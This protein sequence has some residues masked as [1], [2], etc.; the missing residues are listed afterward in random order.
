MV[1]GKQAVAKQIGNAVPA[2]LEQAVG[3]ALIS[4]IRGVAFD[5][6]AA[7]WLDAIGRTII[8]PPSLAADHLSLPFK[9]VA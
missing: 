4:A 1:G 5:Y 8:S 9:V 2:R 6:E 7:L 3:L